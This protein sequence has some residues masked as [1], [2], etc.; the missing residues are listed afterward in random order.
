M[1][2]QL[3]YLILFTGC[4]WLLLDDFFGDGRITAMA[5]KVASNI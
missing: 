1:Q 4:L 2:S 3:L 5:G